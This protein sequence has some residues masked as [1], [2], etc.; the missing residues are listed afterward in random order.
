[1]RRLL[2]AATLIACCIAPAPP[3]AVAKKPRQPPR[4]RA[5]RVLVHCLQSSGCSMLMLLVGQVAKTVSI[6]DLWIISDVPT[7]SEI[8]MVGP[9]AVDWFFLKVTVRG[10]DVVDSL[11]HLKLMKKRFRPDWTILFMRHPVDNFNSMY[12]HVTTTA[13]QEQVV[14]DC[15]AGTDVDR[16]GYG[17]E[18]SLVR[19]S[20]VPVSHAL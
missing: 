19:A 12:R 18:Y 15:S 17:C 1:M 14:D 13:R 11:L 6:V 16:I 7:A 2:L 8:E 3:F 10:E 4:R 9:P 5:K 20:L